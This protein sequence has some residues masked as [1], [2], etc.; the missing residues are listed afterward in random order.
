M[1]F[2]MTK[3]AGGVWV[4]ASDN[5]AERLKRFPSGED[6]E[7][8]IKLPRNPK[9]HRKGFALLNFIYHY[10]C[11]NK[12]GIEFL[13]NAAQFDVFRKQLTIL[14]GYRKEV[15]NLRNLQVS[16]E[17]ESLSFANMDDEE[18]E[19]WYNAVVNTSL[20]H[21]FGPNVDENTIN[22]LWSFL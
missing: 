13:G 12:A 21:I 4:P 16:Y 10:W 3:L 2:S 15:V 22:Q 5:D 9:F 7:V 19:G 6:F 17:A 18:F 8:E 11:A 20:C 1:K 14:A